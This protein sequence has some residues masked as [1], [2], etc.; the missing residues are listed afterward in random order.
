MP[1]IS[2]IQVEHVELTKRDEA[3][4][5]REAL[6]TAAQHRRLVTLGDHF[7]VNAKTAP[8][9]VYGYERRSPKYLQ[10]KQKRFGHQRPWEW[11]G[12]SKRY[13]RN[14]SPVRATQYRSTLQ[15]RAPFP[16]N[17]K[18]RRELEAS[19]PED[20]RADARAGQEYFAREAPKKRRKR[21]G[22]I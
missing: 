8:G 4:L 12:R 7:K 1:S 13:I 9:G 11:S 17:D 10:R 14:N 2:L 19:S 22:R 18:R 21:R 3:T 6:R 15:L 16:L 5:L 20:D